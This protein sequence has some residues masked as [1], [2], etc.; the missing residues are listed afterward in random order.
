MVMKSYLKASQ[1]KSSLQQ[2]KMVKANKKAIVQLSLQLK[3]AN[4]SWK[5]T[6]EFK[7]DHLF[8]IFDQSSYKTTIILNHY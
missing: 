5:D 3:R 2:K 7:I 6:M 8:F 1:K 4:K